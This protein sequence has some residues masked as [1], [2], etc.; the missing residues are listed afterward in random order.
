VLS[1]AL[2]SIGAMTAAVLVWSFG[3]YWADPAASLAIVGLVLLSAWHLLRE[4]VDVLMEAAPRGLDLQRVEGELAGLPG[5]RRVHDLHVW[6]IGSGEVCL[7]CHLVV[8]DAGDAT[9]LLSDAYRLLGSRF[10]I[11]HATLQIEPE[12]FAGQTPRS[13]C[14]GACNPARTAS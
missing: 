11:D 2:G 10:G 1:D 6:T 14:A 3:W 13:L 7:S 4:A 8:A 9:A 12:G 5:V